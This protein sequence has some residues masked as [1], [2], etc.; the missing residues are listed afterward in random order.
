MYYYFIADINEC[1][2]RPCENGAKCNDEVNAYNCSCVDGYNGT[3]CETGILISNVI[4]RLLRATKT[5]YN[6][7][8]RY[9]TV[10]STLAI[11]YLQNATIMLSIYI[12]MSTR[13]CML[14]LQR[15]GVVGDAVANIAVISDVLNRTANPT[16]L[17]GF[18]ILIHIRHKILCNFGWGIYRNY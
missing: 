6:T 4:F 8:K 1:N 10:C 9:F 5:F 3:N 18:F 11:E 16:K 13:D 7:R 12:T 15:D 2:S 14:T 17:P